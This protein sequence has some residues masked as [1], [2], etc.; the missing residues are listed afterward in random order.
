MGTKTIRFERQ[1]LYEHIWEKPMT[2]LAA[3]YDLSDVGLRKICKRLSICQT[4]KLIE[5]GKFLYPVFS[6]I[7]IDADVKVMAWEKLEQLPE[8]GIA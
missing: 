8:N 7:S 4:E 2:T 5:G 6:A 3:E 1:K